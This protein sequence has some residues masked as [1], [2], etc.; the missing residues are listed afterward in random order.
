MPNAN[1]AFAGMICVV[2]ASL[3]ACSSTGD[4]GGVWRAQAPLQGD[5]NAILFQPGVDPVGVELVLGEFGP[6]VAGVVRY[7][8]AGPTGPFDL[9]RQESQPN[10]ECSC[11]Y[12]HGGRLDSRTGLLS[13]TL[14][15]CVPGLSTLAP[16]Q[17]RGRFG[18][19]PDGR[20]T[21][22]L[23]VDDP[24]SPAKGA[25]VA[26]AFDRVGQ[27]GDLASQDLLCG[28]PASATTGNLASGL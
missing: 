24:T 13:F 25:T 9:A 12:L 8:H 4:S 10:F 21:G 23:Q 19:Q 1:L 18:I 14:Q 2:L 15:A 6:D 27:S 5:T 28:T 11:A 3:G 17:L 22:T 26:L 20:L 7:Y 16:V